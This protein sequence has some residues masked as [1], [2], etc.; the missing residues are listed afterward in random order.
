MGERHRVGGY[1]TR[2]SSHM[3]AR[4]LASS[5]TGSAILVFIG[6]AYALSMALSLMIGLT[7]GSQSS[8]SGWRFL[9]MAIPAVA[10]L[11]AA[12]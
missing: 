5:R 7:G 3:T 1:D 11:I 4:K 9:S 8:L 10:V 2:S 12:Q 6:I